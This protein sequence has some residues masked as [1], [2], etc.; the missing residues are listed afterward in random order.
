MERRN[1]FS[2]EIAMEEEKDLTPEQEEQIAREVARMN[3]YLVY[4]E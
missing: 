4:G 1:L 3:M 2:E